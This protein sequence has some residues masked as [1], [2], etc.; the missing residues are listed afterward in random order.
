MSKTLTQI[1]GH[2]FIDQSLLLQALTHPSYIN[3]VRNSSDADYQRLEFLGDAV[4]GLV[5]A[6]QLF[7]MFPDFSEGDLSRLRASLVDQRKLAELAVSLKIAPLILLG[8]GADSEGVRTKPSV[9]ADVFEALIGAVYCDSGF[10]AV[11]QVVA[12]IY[13]PLLTSIKHDAPLLCDAKSELQEIL[14]SEKQKSPVYSVVG[15]DGPAHN[16]RFIVK[17]TF[18]DDLTAAG[19]GSSKK[20][21]QQAAAKAALIKLKQIR[22]T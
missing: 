20:T 19:E 13:A 5:L 21:A 11:K 14:A 7:Q 12:N 8:K 2:T 10:A 16:R 15:E 6:D 22:D 18:A 1:L 9:L 17:V 4:L 3:E